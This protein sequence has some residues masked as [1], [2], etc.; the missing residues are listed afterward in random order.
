MRKYFPL[1][2]FQQ[3]GDDQL[4]TAAGTIVQAM[5]GNANFVTPAPRLEEISTVLDDYRQKLESARKRNGSMSTTLKNQAKDLLAEQLRNLGA[6]V[7]IT[8]AGDLAIIQSS[9]FKASAG[10][11]N[12]DTPPTPNGQRLDVGDLEG[13]LVLRFNAVKNANIYEYRF[14]PVPAAGQEPDWSANLFTANSRRNVIGKLDRAREYQ[15]QVR[16]V[17]RHGAS[18]WSPPV[19]QIAH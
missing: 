6:Y 19:R 12:A 9:G 16:A 17:N 18:N 15:V 11:G 7:K 4:S 3:M 1:V 8:A 13:E 5:T 10:Y 2:G 14:A